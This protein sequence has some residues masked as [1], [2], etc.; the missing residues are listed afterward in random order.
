LYGTL[1]NKSQNKKF[2]KGKKLLNLNENRTKQTEELEG[3]SNHK[4]NLALVARI[5]Y[6]CPMRIP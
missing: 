6:L 5:H 4:T 2:K 1:A 3:A